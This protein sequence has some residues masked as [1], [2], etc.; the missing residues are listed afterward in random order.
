VDFVA[1][2]LFLLFEYVQAVSMSWMV[3]AVLGSPVGLQ[4]VWCLG[5]CWWGRWC[6]GWD[7]RWRCGLLGGKSD[8]WG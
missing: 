2:E 7:R 3:L 6:V 5:G 4:V 8:W 1:L